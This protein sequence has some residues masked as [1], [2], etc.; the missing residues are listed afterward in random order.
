ML[1]G[2]MCWMLYIAR[3]G[4]Q[5]TGLQ[6]Y[7]YCSDLSHVVATIEIHWWVWVCVCL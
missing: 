5:I 7:A 3:A 6:I 4:S 2:G 1:L